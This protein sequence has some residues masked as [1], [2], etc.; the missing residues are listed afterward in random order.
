MKDSK[1][2]D[3]EKINPENK[4]YEKKYS[5]KERILALICVCLIVLVY[6]LSLV[7]SF[8]S[9]ETGK[10]VAKIAFGCT[11]VLPLLTWFYI[12]MAGHIFHK[13]TIADFD[14]FGI[15]TEHGN[16][17]SVEKEEKKKKE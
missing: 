16:I 11:F 7:A 17:M 15:P 8:I 1:K 3:L 2:K 12:W 14:F 4:D 9:T 10:L 6:L 13:H 5:K